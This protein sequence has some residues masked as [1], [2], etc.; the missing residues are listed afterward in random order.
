MQ[1]IEVCVGSSCY[2]K[3]AY[4]VLD[5]LVSLVRQH[6]LEQVVQ[7]TGSF[8]MERC[9]HGVSV[10]VDGVIHSVPDVAAARRLFGVLFLGETED[11][12]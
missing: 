1:R 2:L 3:G 4:R 7:I 12:A 6:E 8:C 11:G 10:S 9:T 5:T